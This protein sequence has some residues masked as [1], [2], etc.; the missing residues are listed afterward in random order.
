MTKTDDKTWYEYIFGDEIGR[1]EREELRE[2]FGSQIAAEVRTALEQSGLDESR[3]VVEEGHKPQVEAS[4]GWL[5]DDQDSASELRD[6]LRDADIG[7]ESVGVYVT[8]RDSNGELADLPPDHLP[9]DEYTVFIELSQIQAAVD[10]GASNA[11]S[12]MDNS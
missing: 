8:P 7:D 12:G 5:M 11:Q 4:A 3:Y 10:A 6:V 1:D 9:V 2:E